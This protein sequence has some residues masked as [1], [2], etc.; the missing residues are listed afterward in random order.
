MSLLNINIYSI[1]TK[2]L[3]KGSGIEEYILTEIILF[4]SR[5]PADPSWTCAAGSQKKLSA[6]GLFIQW[7]CEILSSNNRATFTALHLDD[8]GITRLCT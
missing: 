6:K 2:A 1:N 5:R 7:V 8:A 4:L 3:F